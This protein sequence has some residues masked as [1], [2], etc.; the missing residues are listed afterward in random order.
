[1]QKAQDVV[2]LK[3][4]SQF[5]QFTLEAADKYGQWQRVEQHNLATVYNV[6]CVPEK[7]KLYSFIINQMAQK[8]GFHFAQFRIHQFLPEHKVNPHT[9][10]YLAGSETFILRLDT[11][12]AS[13]LKLKDQ[14]VD[15]PAGTA[16]IL[17][18]HTLHEVI[19]GQA[20]RYS[21]VGWGSRKTN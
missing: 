10:D 7:S 18:E 19:A 4:D 21:L 17:P 3:M 16:Y 15:E 8:L 12:G 20:S 1:M 9:D 2:K 14:L 5:C 13:R 11:L 6:W